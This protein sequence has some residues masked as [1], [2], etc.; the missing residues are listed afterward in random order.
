V[1]AG[2]QVHEEKKEAIAPDPDQGGGDSGKELPVFESFDDMDLKETLLRGVYAYGFVK[3]SYIQQRGIRPV[4]EGKDTIAQAQS[5]TGKTGCFA[6]AT[7]DRI[8]PAVP[9]AQAV[10][11]APTRELAIQ[12]QLVVAAMSQYMESLT[13]H[14]F[15]GGTS[16]RQDI[17]IAREGCQVVVGT[18]GRVNDLLN[19]GALKITHLKLLVLDEADEMLSRGFKEQIYDV[20]QF[21]P[22]DVQVALFSA[23]MP[24]EVLE[25][26]R[27]FMR[28]PVRILVK[29]EEVTLR[30][31]KQFYVNVEREDY[32]FDCLADLYGTL[33]IQQAIIYCNRKQRV[34]WLRDKM[35]Q[36]DFTVACI[37]GEMDWHQRQ[38]VMETFRAGTSR[39]LI[40]TDLTARGIDV[41]GVSLVI[42]YDLPTNLETYIHRVGRSGRY[43]RKGVA[44]NLVTQNDAQKLQDLERFWSTCIEELPQDCADLV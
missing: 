40:S 36:H 26:T 8:D 10:I 34:E 44:I 28:D 12:N 39:V 30:G 31:I 2:G 24:K 41:Y 42:N 14:H 1:N 16:V 27:T 7:L 20:F 6:I 37:H 22:S 33:S 18:P 4:V 17:Q 29:E 13:S 21:L 23:T 11:L 19:R 15:I 9:F 43:G 32:K 5:G 3:P 38:S 25:L 35:T